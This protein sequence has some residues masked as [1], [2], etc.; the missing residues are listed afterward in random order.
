MLLIFFINLVKYK[1]KLIKKMVKRETEGG[2]TVR[3]FLPFLL[4]KN[5]FLP[6]QL[7]TR[8]SIPISHASSS[9]AAAE[10]GDSIDHDD[11]RI[12]PLVHIRRPLSRLPRPLRRRRHVAKLLYKARL[13]VTH[14]LISSS[15]FFLAQGNPKRWC[16]RA[17]CCSATPSRSSPSAPAAGAPPSPTPTPARWS[18][19]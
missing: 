17:W 10:E 7:N 15:F 5:K 13:S 2:S 4:Q 18:S 11:T 8:C 9:A 14:S 3:W 19:T 6:A 1:K 12:L 16:G